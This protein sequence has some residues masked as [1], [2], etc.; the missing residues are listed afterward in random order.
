MASVIAFRIKLTY[1][2]DIT[3][4]YVAMPQNETLCIRPLLG[5][6]PFFSKRLEILVI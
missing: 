4:T 3:T 6:I 1:L 5:K 2:K